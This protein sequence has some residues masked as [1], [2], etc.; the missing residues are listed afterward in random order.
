MCTWW[1]TLQ[2][3]VKRGGAG[4]HVGDCGPGAGVILVSRGWGFGFGLDFGLQAS[5]WVLPYVGN[6][7][8]F[9]LFLLEKKRRISVIYRGMKNLCIILKQV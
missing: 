6:G 7:H 1:S 2:K 8:F 9:S 4:G 3:L 5:E